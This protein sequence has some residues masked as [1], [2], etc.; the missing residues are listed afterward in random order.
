MRYTIDHMFG[1]VLYVGISIVLGIIISAFSEYEFIR[2]YFFMVV[3]ALVV[4]GSLNGLVLLPVV[5]SLIGPRPEIRPKDGGDLMSPP[6]P[7][8]QRSPAYRPEFDMQ[9]KS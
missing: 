4:L 9:V 1:P 3:C 6:T 2:R 8:A 7:R 5:L